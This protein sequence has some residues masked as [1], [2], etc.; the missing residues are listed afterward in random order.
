MMGG[1][2]AEPRPSSRPPGRPNGE[3]GLRPD[4]ED[5]RDDSA[6]EAAAS[7]HGGRSP[8]AAAMRLPRLIH[9]DALHGVLLLLTTGLALLTVYQSNHGR[10]WRGSGDGGSEVGRA[11]E[12]GVPSV[13]A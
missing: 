3:H 1:G 7:S 9:L 10:L 6:A 11:A 8:F 13:C 5:G 4:Q 2:R 12:R